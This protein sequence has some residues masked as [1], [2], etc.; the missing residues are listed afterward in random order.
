MPLF[1]GGYDFILYLLAVV[2]MFGAQMKVQS[3]YSRFS[4]MPANTRFTGRD[5]AQLI[6]SRQG[7]HDVCVEAVAG[8]LSVHYDPRSK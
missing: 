5:V 1:F 2:L 3:A 7:M 8:L 6:L 4:R